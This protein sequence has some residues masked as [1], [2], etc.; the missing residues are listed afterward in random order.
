M[1]AERGLATTAVAMHVQVWSQKSLVR[2]QHNLM[3]SN[4][5]ILPLHVA[6]RP[7]QVLICARLE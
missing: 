2:M 5:D 4:S 1:G 6:R 7:I 3:S